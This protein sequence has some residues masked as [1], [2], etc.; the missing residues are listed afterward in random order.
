MEYRSW[1]PIWLA[2]TFALL[3]ELTLIL[4]YSVVV[5]LFDDW[6]IPATFLHRTWLYLPLAI[7]LFWFLSYI[8]Y[9]RFGGIQKL[10]LIAYF[11]WAFPFILVAIQAINHNKPPGIY[12]LV[13]GCSLVVFIASVF[14]A[15]F[16]HVQTDHGGL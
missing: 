4:F 1:M 10:P 13:V 3:T 14:V 9:T 2:W 8:R 11:I 15:G 7:P 12:A 5:V 6:G 16:K